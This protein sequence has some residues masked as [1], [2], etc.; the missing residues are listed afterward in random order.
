MTIEITDADYPPV[1][2]CEV[3]FTKET[4]FADAGEVCIPADKEECDKLRMALADG[5]WWL[6]SQLSWQSKDPSS[7]LDA[8]AVMSSRLEIIGRNVVLAVYN[9]GYRDSDM[10][11][12]SE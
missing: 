4:F 7:M 6:Q 10:G 11:E 8:S 5:L 2:K 9:N 1:A 12:R 3:P